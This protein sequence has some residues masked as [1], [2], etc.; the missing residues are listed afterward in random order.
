MANNPTNAVVAV[1]DSHE[2]AE[3]AIRKLA[4]GKIPMEKLSVIGKGYH[5]EEKVVG[6]YNTG[7]RV[8]FWGKFGAFWGALWGLLAGGLYMTVPLIGPVVVLGHFAAMVLAAVEGAV[9]TGG[10][11]ALGAALFSIGIPKNT[12]LQYEQAVKADG[13]LVLVQGTQE[14]AERARALLQATAPTQV[15]MHCCEGGSMSECDT[16]KAKAAS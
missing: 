4:D 15:D 16:P 2:R 14:E 13:F 1:Y 6:F 8:K 7:D 11:S 9:L 12:V 3:D 10:V 5:T